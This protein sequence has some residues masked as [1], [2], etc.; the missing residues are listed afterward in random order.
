MISYSST[1]GPTVISIG[2]LTERRK[3][4]W[5]FGPYFSCHSHVFPQIFLFLL[6]GIQAE[7]PFVPRSLLW[8]SV[9][10]TAGFTRLRQHLNLRLL[11]SSPS[12]SFVSVLLLLNTHLVVRHQFQAW[13]LFFF[14]S[15]SF[16]FCKERRVPSSFLMFLFCYIVIDFITAFTRF[17]WGTKGTSFLHLGGSFLPFRQEKQGKLWSPKIFLLVASLVSL[18][19]EL[20]LMMFFHGFPVFLLWWWSWDPPSS[21][22]D[23]KSNSLSSWRSIFRFSSSFSLFPSLTLSLFFTRSCHKI[24]GRMIFMMVL[25]NLLYLRKR[26]A[27][28]SWKRRMINQHQ[29]LN[30][31]SWFSSLSKKGL[32]SWFRIFL[33]W[34]GFLSWI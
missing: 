3:L 17:P 31:S 33:G 15:Q 20:F 23:W 13:Q 11:H 7:G 21:L 4:S 25:P 2:S 22:L 10:M 27:N 30:P 9:N 18:C 8:S 6:R 1:K 14:M 16:S 29:A 12:S 34:K 26:Y 32:I 28:I 19:Y 24:Q 5:H